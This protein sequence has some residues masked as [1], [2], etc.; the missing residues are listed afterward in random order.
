M[1]RGRPS[2]EEKRA[3]NIYLRPATWREIK[4]RAVDRGTS[5]TELIEEAVERY[6]AETRQEQ[7]QV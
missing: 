2:K 1:P 6:L 3:T 7:A 4:H 5:M